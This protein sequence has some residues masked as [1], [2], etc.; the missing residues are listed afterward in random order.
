MPDETARELGNDPVLDLE[1]DMHV[2][3]VHGLDL[4]IVAPGAV[5]GELLPELLQQETRARW[6]ENAGVAEEQAGAVTDAEEDTAAE[7]A[8]AAETSE[9]A[10]AE[11]PAE[12]EKGGD[13]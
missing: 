12:E 7:P 11:A 5:I 3:S 2:A 8:G 9:P 13:V 1:I 6:V 10:P 4:E